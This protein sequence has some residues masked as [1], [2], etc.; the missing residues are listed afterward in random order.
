MPH[1]SLQD[2]SVSVIIPSKNEYENLKVL[3]PAITRI[4]YDIVIIDASEDQS[5]RLLA[6]HYG[7]KYV[8]Q[9]SVGKGAAVTSAP[10]HTS[11]KILVFIDADCSH[12][13]SDIIKL[14]EPLL[15][16]VADLVIGSRM[17]G[18][19][20]ELFSGIREFIR[21]IGGH[22]ITLIIAKRFNHGL[23]D[24]QNGFRAIKASVL[25]ELNLQQKSFSIET[26]MCIEALR[27]GFRVIEVRTHE[28]RRLNGNSNIN[29]FLLAPLYGYVTLKG[30]IMPRIRK[31]FAKVNFDNEQYN[32]RW[33]DENG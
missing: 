8:R 22:I 21:L 13:P 31:Q 12:N 29:P 26:E 25:T 6:N 7:V 3:L 33:H 32:P 1:R 20:D 19:S 18:G 4:G 11:A 5:T 9:Q 10:S 16:D 28:Y 15:Q 23:T 27:R 30:V 2:N 14:T 24:S 17:R